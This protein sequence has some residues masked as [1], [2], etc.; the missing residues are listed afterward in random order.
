MVVGSIALHSTIDADN[1]NV[2]ISGAV[3][4]HCMVS[5]LRAAAPILQDP[6]ATVAREGLGAR[7]P[8]K[9]APLLQGHMALRRRVFVF[10]VSSQGAA[11]A[12]RRRKGMAAREVIQ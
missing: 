10:S 11:L 8:L 2:Y 1:C 12:L 4:S 6:S 9:Q 5:G 7:L 3:L